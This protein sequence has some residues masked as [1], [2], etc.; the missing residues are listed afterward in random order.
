MSLLSIYHDGLT[1]TAPPIGKGRKL[2][3]YDDLLG[4]S[5]ELSKY[6]KSK[7]YTL[8]TEENICHTNV[9]FVDKL[10]AISQTGNLI[11]DIVARLPLIFFN[12]EGSLDYEDINALFDDIL[13][14]ISEVTGL[15]FRV[16]RRRRKESNKCRSV[17]YDCR[18][19]I[20]LTSKP[21]SHSNIAQFKCRGLLK[22]ILKKGYG[23]VEI[24]FSHK[25]NHPLLPII[26]VPEG[27]DEYIRNHEC[28]KVSHLIQRLKTE[29]NYKDYVSQPYAGVRSHIRS[30]WEKEVASKWTKAKNALESARLLSSSAE[31]TYLKELRLNEVAT[32]AIGGH[33]IAFE[34]VYPDFNKSKF[35]SAGID[36]TYH[37]T[38]TL[39]QC[40]AI[41]AEYEGEGYPIGILFCGKNG[42]TEN[43]IHSFL[44]VVIEQGYEFNYIT[45]DSDLRNTN[46]ITK[47]LSRSRCQLC[48][49]HI[50]KNVSGYERD[51]KKNLSEL[52]ASLR[53]FDWF[54]EREFLTI[55]DSSRGSLPP[56]H[57]SIKG[58]TIAILNRALRDNPMYYAETVSAQDGNY[59]VQYPKTPMDLYNLY[60]KTLY[61][62]IVVELRDIYF[63]A[64][65]YEQLFSKKR[66]AMASAVFK[67][68]IPRMTNML[69]EAFFKTL[70]HNDLFRLRSMR[71]DT[72]LYII[73]AKI[74]QHFFK[75]LAMRS[76]PHRLYADIASSPPSWMRK[77]ISDVNDELK[78][79]SI[80][81]HRSTTNYDPDL[82]LFLCPCGYQKRSANRL[83]KHIIHKLANVYGSSHISHFIYSCQR[84]ETLPFIISP[85]SVHDIRSLNGVTVPVF[86]N[87]FPITALYTREIDYTDTNIN[88]DDDEFISDDEFCQTFERVI[89]LLEGGAEDFVDNYYNTNVGENEALEEDNNEPEHDDV[90][91]LALQNSSAKFQAFTDDLK[92]CLERA[93]SL[94]NEDPGY[95]NDFMDHNPNIP[96]IC[97]YIGTIK[98]TLE[99][100]DRARNDSRI[101]RFDGT[102][103]NSP[104]TWY[105]G[106]NW[107]RYQKLSVLPTPESLTN[108]QNDSAEQLD[109]HRLRSDSDISLI[110]REYDDN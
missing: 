98:Y 88:E 36:G 31:L 101:H 20:N 33:Y 6:I 26:P 81:N 75:K 57:K 27:L 21:G 17:T 66:F 45:T 102:S 61:D 69:V 92:I 70:K 90:N 5:D 47:I 39:Q 107:S 34:V 38:S 71:L 104:P 67:Q 72:V 59:I 32:T 93:E 64:Y 53:N 74:G 37:I 103:S 22:M 1:Y 16:K 51:E 2:N 55:L 42:I 83:C 78:E 77:M 50:F 97:Q 84:R 60:L 44:K 87:S 3:M 85:F 49:W 28:F 109:G 23:F 43:V 8:F 41:V 4:S 15:Q 73:N 35:T 30:I 110:S 105:T 24:S 46:S 10:K 12:L 58:K 108:R 63:F 19:Y 11:F 62:Y 13:E 56:I 52:Q 48:I 79:M 18:Q 25:M 96:K 94:L 7:R 82:G 100:P 40:H 91:N 65:I 106:N 80:S 76:N 99:E 9:E 14:D 86:E 29:R 54:N 95:L 89:D 68:C